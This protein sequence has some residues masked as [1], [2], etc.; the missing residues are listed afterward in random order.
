MFAC[1]HDNVSPTSCL[2]RNHRRLSS[3]ATTLYGEIFGAFLGTM[4]IQ[5]FSAIYPATRR[6]V[7]GEPPFKKEE[8]LVGC[9]PKSPTETAFNGSFYLPHVATCV[10]GYG[11][12]Q[13]V[14]TKREKTSAKRIGHKVIREARKRG[15]IRL[16]GTSSS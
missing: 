1:E 14:Q 15:I 4:T 7:A 9:S 8:I 16:W 10:M 3:L 12:Y 5:G 13:L 6:L 11:R 2:A